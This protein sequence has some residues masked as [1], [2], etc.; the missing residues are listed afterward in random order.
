MERKRGNWSR[1]RITKGDGVEVRL[2]DRLRNV[3]PRER[4]NLIDKHR[5]RSNLTTF[6]FSLLLNCCRLPSPSFPSPLNIESNQFLVRRICFAELP[7][8]GVHQLNEPTNEQSFQSRL[9]RFKKRANERTNDRAN[10]ETIE[11]E[12][13]GWIKLESRVERNERE[14]ESCVQPLSFA[15]VELAVSFFEHHAPRSGEERVSIHV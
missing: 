13:S 2:G 7:T 3:G 5:W 1:A 6:S 15:S 8:A 4:V 11:F 9:K 10:E 14:K 12:G